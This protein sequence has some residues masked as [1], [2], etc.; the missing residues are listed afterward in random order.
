MLLT[1]QAVIQEDRKLKENS[2]QNGNQSAGEV[3]EASGVNE[4]KSE[5]VP[6]IQ[7]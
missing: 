5:C 4:L 7:K 2:D 3:N 6:V 1:R